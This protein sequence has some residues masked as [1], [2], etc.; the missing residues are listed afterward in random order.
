MKRFGLI[1]LFVVAAP[2]CVFSD[3]IP[4]PDDMG[5]GFADQG[6]LDGMPD[7]PPMCSDDSM[8][9]VGAPVCGG[10]GQCGGCQLGN[11]SACATH[12]AATP[13]C[14]PS[15]GCVECLSKDDCAT[16]NQTCNLTSNACAPCQA[17]AD[18]S[19]GVCKPGGVCA[20][21]A[22]VAY[23]NNTNS[24]TV[25]CSDLPHTSTR[26]SPYCQIQAA[27]TQST[28]PPF[29]LVEGSATPYD[30]VSL[31]TTVKAIGP[32][33]I[34]GPGRGAAQG[35][36]LA[37]SGAVTPNGFALL[38][39]GGNAATVTLEGLTL[40]GAGGATP[41]AG[42]RCTV[43]VGAATLTIRDC[44]IQMSG[45]AGVDTNGCTITLDRNV[46]GPSNTGGGVILGGT[47]SYTITNNIIAGNGTGVP[48]VDIANMATGTF[49]FNTVANNGGAG[50]GSPPGGISCPAT[51][52]VIQSSIVVGNRLTM[53][54]GTQFFG[55]CTLMNVV[56]G[57][58]NF[59]G[60]SMLSPDLDA[61]FRLTSATAND[62]CCID[63]VTSPTTPNASRD[64]DGSM[65]PKGA[66]HDIGAH[67]A[68]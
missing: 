4:I 8:C 25:T 45:G 40:I 29:V 54:G 68:R 51:A 11:N 31:N 34:I 16:K 56:T 33:T 12:H 52:R 57:A 9:P 18:C 13:L 41:G 14:G 20:T 36:T 15:G 61:S 37:G 26:T 5:D 55:N 43:G 32:L 44:K 63:K 19:T 30:P 21:A 50:T 2:G 59:A 42:A 49:A 27:V 35:A 66:A 28:A 23:V 53:A 17:H 7:M 67:E 24:S 60:A 1:V 6:G 3:L 58:D 47:T 39:G 65:R 62:T 46:I 48:A 38:T 22:E 10:G 64:I